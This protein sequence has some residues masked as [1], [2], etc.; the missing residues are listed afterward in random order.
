M[1]N[2]LALTN[3]ECYHPHM[4]LSIPE[5]NFYIKK[6][7]A[8]PITYRECVKISAQLSAENT[9]AMGESEETTS[10]FSPSLRELRAMSSAR[11]N[12]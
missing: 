5:E 4:P 8:L 3:F 7:N 10:V 2:K 11:M 12:S 6:E 9:R 1:Y